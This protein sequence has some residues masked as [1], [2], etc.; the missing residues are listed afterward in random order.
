MRLCAVQQPEIRVEAEHVREILKSQRAKA[1]ESGLGEEIADIEP[2]HDAYAAEVMMIFCYPRGVAHD[3]V[4][5]LA[6]PQWRKLAADP[7]QRC[8]VPLIEF[9]EWTPEAVD[10]EDGK[11]PVKGEMWFQVTTSRSSQSP[12]SGSTPPPAKASRW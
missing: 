6:L 9:C 10:L 12:A 5:N 7:A 4:R 3:D 11:K 1:V 2:F 8:L